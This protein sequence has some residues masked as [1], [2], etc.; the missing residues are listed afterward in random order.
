M[1]LA[2]LFDRGDLGVAGIVC[3]GCCRGTQEYKGETEETQQVDRT[4]MN[5]QQ[6]GNDTVV[7]KERG[8]EKAVIVV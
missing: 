2:F 1:L 6:K 8:E 3:K 7:H 5:G 4:M